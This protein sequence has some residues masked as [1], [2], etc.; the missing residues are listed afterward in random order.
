MDITLRRAGPKDI[1]KIYRIME[2]LVGELNEEIAKSGEMSGIYA[3][4]PYRTYEGIQDC[5]LK[6]YALMAECDGE[7]AGSIGIGIQTQ[8]FSGTQ[9]LWNC[10]FF[11]YP[12]YRN[13]RAAVMMI[14]DVKQYAEHAGMPLIM[15]ISSLRD[16]DRKNRLFSRYFTPIGGWFVQ[17]VKEP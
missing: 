11:V 7:T 6:S 16:V 12:E 9:N 10:W 3:L 17:G 14:K 1:P 15:G 8:W 13:S 5:V 2:A 4:D